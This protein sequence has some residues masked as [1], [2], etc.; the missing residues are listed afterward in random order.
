MLSKIIKESKLNLYVILSKKINNLS[1]KSNKKSDNYSNYK[2][3]IL[4]G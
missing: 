1:N 2:I 4:N 3:Y